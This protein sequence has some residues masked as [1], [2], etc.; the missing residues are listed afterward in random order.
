MRNCP[1]LMMPTEIVW[2]L[3]RRVFR[4]PERIGRVLDVSAEAAGARMAELGL[5]GEAKP[6][7]GGEPHET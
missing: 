3:W 6:I 5:G 2:W 1:S 4:D 7:R